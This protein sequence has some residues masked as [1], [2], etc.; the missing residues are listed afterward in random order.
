MSKLF[1][2]TGNSKRRWQCFVC[3]KQYTTYEEY[4]DH[5]V[6]E[7]EEG[8]EYIS[9]PDCKAPVRHLPSHY[10]TKHRSRIMPKNVQ[11]RVAVW[12]DFSSSGKKKKTR[13]PTF[14]QGYFESNKMNGNLYY[15]RSGYEREVYDFLES[16]SDVQAYYAEPFKVPYHHKGEWHDYIPD[17]R[18]EFIDGS[19][20]IWEIK[21]A[22]QT[23]YDINQS[24]WAAAANFA[25]NHGWKFNVI[26][27][28]GMG[29]LKTK[30]MRQQNSE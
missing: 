4:K 8:R 10:K 15:Y 20:E 19:V 5:I 11:T 17:L 25:E 29:K 3:G 2:D 6:Q 1:E 12:H 21:P 9:C 24:K 23:H 30:I 16:D 18:I 13:K 27:E 22:N 28:V 14:D 26:T 7:H